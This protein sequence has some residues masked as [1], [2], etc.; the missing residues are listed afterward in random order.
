MEYV[1]V[2]HG[3]DHLV[4]CGG[5]DGHGGGDDDDADDDDNNDDDDDDDDHNDRTSR[6]TATSLSTSHSASRSCSAHAPL[7]GHSDTVGG[8]IQ[9]SLRGGGASGEGGK[10]AHPVL[11]TRARLRNGGEKILEV[12]VQYIRTRPHQRARAHT[13]TKQTRAPVRE[14]SR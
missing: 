5:D 7:G 2:R 12:I 10:G 8:T 9:F 3:G 14:I 6:F 1:L 13:H 11:S 4:S